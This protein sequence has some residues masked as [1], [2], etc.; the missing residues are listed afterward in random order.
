MYD[1]AVSIGSRVGSCSS[2]GFSRWILDDL[3]NFITE[4]EATESRKGGHSAE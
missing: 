3:Q 1:L 2:K 4:S